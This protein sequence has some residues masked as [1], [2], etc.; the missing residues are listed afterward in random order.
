GEQKML[1]LARAYVANPSIILLD[2]ASLGLAP[3]IVDAIF[4][5]VHK[6]TAEGVAVLLVEQYVSKA[7]AISDH[8]YILNRGRITFD[9][10]PSQLQNDDI[11]RHYLGADAPPVPSGRAGATGAHSG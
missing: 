10:R 6:L 11:L 2:E 8:V 7:L 4:A 9:G 1:A 5:F 3:Q